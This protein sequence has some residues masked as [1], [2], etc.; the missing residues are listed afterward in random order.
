[1]LISYKA[2][3][4]SSDTRVWEFHRGGRLPRFT[5]PF[6]PGNTCGYVSRDFG[7][8]FIS[9]YPDSCQ[10]RPSGRNHPEKS[11]LAAGGPE[12]KIWQA[13]EYQKTR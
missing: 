2:T 10:Y 13:I 9:R 12:G 5:F 4:S 1:M 7:F 3:P 6:L 11:N 8:G